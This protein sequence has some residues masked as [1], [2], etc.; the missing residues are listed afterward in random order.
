MQEGSLHGRSA[1]LN[2]QCYMLQCGMTL[3]ASVQAAS[4]S[5][6]HPKLEDDTILTALI[7][8][9]VNTRPCNERSL[10]FHERLGFHEVGRQQSEG[11]S[12]EV[13]MLELLA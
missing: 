9:Q 10:A 8:T 6:V 3:Q 7:R 13:A 1:C 5:A 2:Q 4:A 12:K 11:G